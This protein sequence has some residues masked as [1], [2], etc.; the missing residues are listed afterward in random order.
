MN[1]RIALVEDN[2]GLRKRFEEYFS[3]YP[4]ITLEASY[5][6]G[7]AALNGIR[8]MPPSRLPQVVLMDIELPG[9][10]GIETTAQLRA[11][12]PEVEV[13]MLTVFEDQQRIL[14]SIQAGACGYLLKDEPP[15]VIIGAL[16]DCM[17][18]GAP[19]SQA[20]AR[21]VLGILRAPVALQASRE[22]TA[23]TAAAFELSEREV[24]L[25][26]GLVAGETYITLAEK[27]FISPHTVR[28][29]IRNIYQKLHVHSRAQAV[30]TA[31]EKK[32]V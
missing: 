23:T 31:M 12:L 10:T 25:L 5:A 32:L 6:S 29:H 24:E 28:T 18:G 14:E 11:V 21:K 27:L 16:E 20:I 17:N 15:D 19:I 9:I 1:I 2:P 22:Q 26:K 8:T 3:L 13:I 4:Q 30:R 7:E